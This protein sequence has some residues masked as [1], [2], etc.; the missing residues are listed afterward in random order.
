MFL[1]VIL[2]ILIM[3][4]ESWTIT[5]RDAL[6]WLVVAGMIVAKRVELTRFGSPSEGM[7]GTTS[8]ALLRY[9]IVLIAVAGGVWV[10]AQAV[11]V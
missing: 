7:R 4:A 3:R 8:P 1:L 6:F 11:S 5:L 2:T 10:V 9:A